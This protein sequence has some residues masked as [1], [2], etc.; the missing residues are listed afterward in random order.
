[1]KKVKTVF[2]LNQFDAFDTE[3]MIRFRKREYDRIC[4]QKSKKNAKNRAKKNDY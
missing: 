2:I 4:K 1:M 3:D